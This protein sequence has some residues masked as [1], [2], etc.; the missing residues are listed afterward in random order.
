MLM[1][2][3]LARYGKVEGLTLVADEISEW[4][5]AEARPSSEELLKLKNEYVSQNDFKFKRERELPSLE[6]KVN[7]MFE[8][9]ANSSD[10]MLDE[11]KAK[12]SAIEVKYPEPE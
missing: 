2:A 12:V 7:A 10:V 4:P 11:V 3:L 8:K 9:L 5:Y 1:E 6:E